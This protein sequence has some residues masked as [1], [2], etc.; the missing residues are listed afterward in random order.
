M[1]MA[2][3]LIW[4]FVIVL[5]FSILCLLSAGILWAVSTLIPS[6][7][8]PVTFM[9]SLAGGFILFVLSALLSK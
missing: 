4:L 2:L 9:T 7:E 5:K 6:L 1:K 8:I 3:I